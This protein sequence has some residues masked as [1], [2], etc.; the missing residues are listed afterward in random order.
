SDRV[1]AAVAVEIHGVAFERGR[2]ELRWPERA[3]PGAD[4]L[5]GPQVT[6]VQ[7]FQRRQKLIAEIGLA[8]A[9][10]GE[11]RGRAQHGTVAAERAVI[12]LDAPDRGDDVTV[13]A[14]GLLDLVEDRLV[15]GKQFAAGGDARLAHQ[16]V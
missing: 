13:D 4:Q 10:A 14:V 15:A 16:D 11:S 12:R 2:H 7:D 6:A 3:G 8:R 5:L 9:D 1:T